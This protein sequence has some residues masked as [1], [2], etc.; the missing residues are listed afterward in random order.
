MNLTELAAALG[1]LV[2]VVN[3]IAVVILV[4]RTDDLVK[5]T[6][7]LENRL[8]AAERGSLVVMVRGTQINLNDFLSRLT[9]KL[10]IDL[11]HHEEHVT[12]EDER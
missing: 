11:V 8:P 6:D 5:R 1:W 12:L 2:S 9:R 3:L 7:N 4:K 10:K